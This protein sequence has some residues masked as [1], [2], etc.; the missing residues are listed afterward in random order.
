VSPEGHR[1][2]IGP[3]PMEHKSHA[4][5]PDPAERRPPP[6]RGLVS[7]GCRSK[8]CAGL[9]AV[10]GLFLL[11]AVAWMTGMPRPRIAGPLPPE[12]T[13]ERALARRLEQDVRE[14]AV[15]IGE[16]NLLREGSMQQAAAWIERRL[17]EAGYQ[18]ERHTYELTGA[19]HGV[20]AGMFADNLIAELPGLEKREEIMVLGAHYDSVPGSPGANDNASAVAVLLALAERLAGRPRA[21]TVRFVAFA[22]EEPPFFLSRDM[23]SYAYAE[24][25]RQRG[26]EIVAMVA[27]DGLGYFSQEPGSQ[28]FPAPGLGLLYPDRGEFI[29]MV[30]RPRDLRFLRRALA[31]FRQQGSLPAEGV[32]LPSFIPGV[33]WS[34]HWSFWQH[35][36]PGLLVTD[37]LP[38]RDP[39]YHTP[40]D[41]AD[42]LDYLRMARV[43]VGL[44]AVVEAL[45]R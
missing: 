12:T 5:E 40:E 15:G 4:T 31:S 25:C 24:R 33:A 9:A 22:N 11:G 14:L 7:K 13:D 38:Y 10:V 3:S 28:S 6:S 44:E 37:T 20:L 2:L 41:T 30:T 35:G 8:G 29:G 23:G 36:Y 26:E 39:A 19:G 1:C 43:A 34:D 21:R 17:R 42:R 16:R 27:M 45:A 18:P 32:A